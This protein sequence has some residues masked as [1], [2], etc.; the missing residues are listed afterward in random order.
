MESYWAL[1]KRGYNGVFHHFT[2]KHLHRYL[3]EFETRWN[4]GKIDGDGRL[5]SV[6]KAISGH[7][8]TYERLIHSS[9]LT[10]FCWLSGVVRS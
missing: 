3:A 1:L 5:D 8:L 6:L 9:K 7:R 2:W 10:F 4:M